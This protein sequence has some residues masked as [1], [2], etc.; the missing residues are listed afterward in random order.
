MAIWHRTTADGSGAPALALIPS[1]ISASSTL[2][3][4]ARRFAAH[5]FFAELSLRVH[6]CQAD[7][8]GDYIRN[9]VP[10]LAK[11]FGDGKH[12]IFTH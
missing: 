11:V 3:H 8:T 2:I 10:E 4:K 12:A 6:H 7:P 9:F 1:L 5:I